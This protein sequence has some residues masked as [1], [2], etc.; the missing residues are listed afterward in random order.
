MNHSSLMIFILSQDRKLNAVFSPLYVTYSCRWYW[1]AGTEETS[2]KSNVISFRGKKRGRQ[3]KHLRMP[4]F[5]IFSQSSLTLRRTNSPLIELPLQ[6]ELTIHLPKER[7]I[8]T[9]TPSTGEMAAVCIPSLRH[10]SYHCETKD[11]PL[12]VMDSFSVFS[13][14]IHHISL[15][16]IQSLHGVQSHDGTEMDNHLISPFICLSPPP[17]HHRY[18]SNTP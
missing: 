16:H 12:S 18:L 15:W 8:S 14:M 11:E 2:D 3:Y 13:S 5:R 6:F 9:L 7:V 4:R 10:H 17:P 1:V